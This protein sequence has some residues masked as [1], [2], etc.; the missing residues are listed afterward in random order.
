MIIMSFS[1]PELKFKF[2]RSNNWKFTL[3]KLCGKGLLF[4]SYIILFYILSI[5]FNLSSIHFLLNFFLSGVFCLAIVGV[6]YHFVEMNQF[7]DWMI[8]RI[9]ERPKNRLYVEFHKCFNELQLVEKKIVNLYINPL[10]SKVFLHARKLSDIESVD[11][12]ENHYER[13]LYLF[14]KLYPSYSEQISEQLITEKANKH[15]ANSEAMEVIWNYHLLSTFYP[16]EM[17][18]QINEFWEKIKNSNSDIEINSELLEVMNQ[19]SL[20]M[21]ID[22]NNRKAYLAKSLEAL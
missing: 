12:I 18:D 6:L 7:Q 11:I 15:I 20:S 21:M 9:T 8:K 22:M 1:Y 5:V 4:I 16:D 17:A 14:K 10:K 2:E 3:I 19:V 13:Y